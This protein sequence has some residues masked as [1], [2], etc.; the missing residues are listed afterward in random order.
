MCGI[1]FGFSRSGFNSAQ[2][3]FL[4][5][6]ILSKLRHRGPDYSGSLTKNNIYFGHTRLAING[7]DSKFNQPYT[8]T[9]SDVL[10]YNGEIYSYKNKPFVS[11]SDNNSDTDFLLRNL[12]NS[13]NTKDLS[14]FLN[15]L[16]GMW[17]F[18]YE[19]NNQIIFW[20]KAPNM[21]L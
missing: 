7:L 3:D 5:S 17:A 8:N 13:K 10:L 15:N 9:N 11:Y 19:Y 1:L 6:V 16:E 4:N 18:I 2:V 12:E 20:T 21:F 14:Q